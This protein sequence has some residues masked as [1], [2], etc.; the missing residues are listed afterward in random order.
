M[1]G[2]IEGRIVHYV[3]YNYRHLMGA[4]IGVEDGG[5]ADLVI[6]TNMK[7]AA[8]NKSFGMQFHQD[9]EYSAEPRPGTWHWTSDDKVD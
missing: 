6:F 1:E 9:V 4:V 8:G 3:A 5:K 2:L 7:N